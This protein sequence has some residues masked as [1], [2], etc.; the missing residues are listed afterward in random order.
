MS[1]KTKNS[2]IKTDSEPKV[3]VKVI[4]TKRELENLKM[5]R[6]FGID[7]LQKY[8]RKIKA[9]IEVFEVAIEKERT[10]M[11][12]VQTMIDVLEKDIK[13]ANKLKKLA[14]D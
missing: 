2:K 7:D 6:Q 11:K 3:T 5:V 12:R 10:E 4:P 9:N 1:T 8:K 13:E 14:H